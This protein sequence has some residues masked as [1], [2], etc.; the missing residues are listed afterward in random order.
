MFWRR[1]RAYTEVSEI[2]YLRLFSY[3]TRSA[4]ELCSTA[5][6][7]SIILQLNQQTAPLNGNILA[8]ITS[9]ATTVAIG[10]SHIKQETPTQ[11]LS[12]LIRG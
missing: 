10:A 11:A 9:S 5:T 3:D 7:I 2:P 1:Y 12:L 4:I 6:Y 8:Q